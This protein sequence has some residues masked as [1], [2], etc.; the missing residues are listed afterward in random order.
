MIRVFRNIRKKFLVKDSTK[1]YFLY[2][3]GE[4]LLIVIGILIALSLDNWNDK[5][6]QRGREVQVYSNIKNRGC[7][8][9][10]V[11]LATLEQIDAISS[12]IDEEL[13]NDST[14]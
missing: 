3:I 13:E 1:R 2:A 6:N 9:E 7:I 4:V 8:K 5:K 11:Y 14:N 10:K 12:L